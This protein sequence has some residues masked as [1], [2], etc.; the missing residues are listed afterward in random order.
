M[1]ILSLIIATL[2]ALTLIVWSSAYGGFRAYFL[3]MPS[4]PL[5]LIFAVTLFFFTERYLKK[6]AGKVV[7]SFIKYRYTLP[8]IAF[9]MGIAIRFFV[10][11]NIPHIQDSIHY[12]MIA[13]W[14]TEGRLSHPPLVSYEFYHYIYFIGS[15]T[16]FY[17]LFLPGYPLFLSLFVM[18]HL[19]WL[20]NPFLLAVTIFLTGRVA[21]KMGGKALSTLTMIFALCSSFVIFMAGTGM[22]HNFTAFLTVGVVLLFYELINSDKTVTKKDY[23]FPFAIGFMVG[24]LMVTRPQNAI[25]LSAALIPFALYFAKDYP[26]K[27]LLYFGLTFIPFAGWFAALLLYN[28]HFTGSPLTFIQDIYFNYSEPTRFCHRLGMGH[29]CFKSN[30][31]VL[32]KAGLTP[33]HAMWVTWKRLTSLSMNLLAHPITLLFPMIAFFPLTSSENK[34]LLLP[35]VLF[36]TSVVGYFFFYFDAN[37]FG[38]RYYYE[39]TFFLLILLAAGV[40]NLSKL[41][42][43]KV[44]RFT[45]IAFFPLLFFF[46]FTTVVPQLVKTYRHGFWDVNV[47]LQQAVQQHNIHNAVVFVS[48]QKLIGSGF[49]VM[50]LRNIEQ[51]DVIYARDLGEEANAALMTRMPARVFYRAAWKNWKDTRTKLPLITKLRTTLEPNHLAIEL[52]QKSYPLA[53]RPDYCNAFPDKRMLNRF[54]PIPPP[55]EL[56]FS[57]NRGWYCRIKQNQCYDFGQYIPTAGEWKIEMRLLVGPKMGKFTITVDGNPITEVDMHDAEYRKESFYF[58]ATLPK[59]F[60][61]FA[62]TSHQQNDNF[63]MLDSMTF[64]RVVAHAE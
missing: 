14:I 62:L 44:V 63:F 18:L 2:L 47:H 45:L 61:I 53:C 6:T 15:P 11:G 36:L 17:S 48:P 30:W 16:T 27:A 12:K 40:L 13:E 8:F 56:S 52:E 25:F 55:Y 46:H 59:G 23:I 24:W 60:H 22:A 29:G 32:P 49:A 43:Q 20:A 38:P 39:T 54:M 34:K 35:A 10:F 50:D 42:P 3:Y 5:A 58:S 7:D 33:L 51:N 21:E 19:V 28:N 41:Y 31:D 37:V 1:K 9:A 4:L 64:D 57:K 26:K